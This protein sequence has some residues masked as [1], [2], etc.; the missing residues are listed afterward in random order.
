MRNFADVGSV[1]DGSEHIVKFFES[2]FQDCVKHEGSEDEAV[3]S[4]KREF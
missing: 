4:V 1:L 3:E 2:G